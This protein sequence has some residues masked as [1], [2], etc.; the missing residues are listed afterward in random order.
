MIGAGGELLG[1]ASLQMQESADSGQIV[2]LNMVVPIDLLTPILDDL[3]T[4]GHMAVPRPW[5]GVLAVESDD[6]VVVAGATPGGPAHRAELRE[7]D[8]I[9]AVAG[10]P[11]SSLADFYRAIWAL[12]PAGVRAPLT[13][14]REDD[15]FDVTITTRDRR[16][17]LKAPML[18]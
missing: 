3:I 16:S 11:V 6:Q 14:Q 8:A 17:Y 15:V 4:G 9:L 18:H 13:V 12:G 1:L 5:L 7:G 10:S 2:P